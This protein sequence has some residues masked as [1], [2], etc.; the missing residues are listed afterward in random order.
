MVIHNESKRTDKHIK[1]LIE[2]AK[3]FFHYSNL[4]SVYIYTAERPAELT[5]GFADK[6]H[7]GTTLSDGVP[8]SVLLRLSRG[9]EYPTSSIYRKS[10]GEIVFEDWKEEFLFVLA[11]EMRHVDQYWS[12]QMPRHPEVDAERYAQYVLDCYRNDVSVSV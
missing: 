7:L 9:M 1:P 8:S 4:A 11:H 2:Y 10:V 12:D 6:F 5:S 3:P